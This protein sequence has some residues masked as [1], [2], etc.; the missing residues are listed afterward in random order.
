MSANYLTTSANYDQLQ[1]TAV[2]TSQDLHTH[3]QHHEHGTMYAES[4]GGTFK[5][6][7]HD[8][9]KVESRVVTVLV[10]LTDLTGEGYTIFPCFGERG[11]PPADVELCES[12]K[13]AFRNGKRILTKGAL[14]DKVK[15]WCDAPPMRA[16]PEQNCGPGRGMLRVEPRAGRAAVFPSSLPDG[17]P[18]VSTWHAGC[19]TQPNHKKY[20]LQ[21]FRELPRVYGEWDYDPGSMKVPSW[22]PMGPD[23]K[24]SRSQRVRNKSESAMLMDPGFPGVFG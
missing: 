17:L 15:L 23:G 7:H 6:V 10:Y 20:T 1:T 3:Y 19:P 2:K 21:F 13:E 5:F 22:R 12:L 11:G 14:F 16:C 18:D 4:I 8:K 24:L 9:N